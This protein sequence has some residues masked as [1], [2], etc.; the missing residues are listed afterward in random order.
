MSECY[1]MDKPILSMVMG[2][3]NGERFLREAIDSI[4]SQTF[5]DFEFIIVDDGSTDSS[6]DIVRSYS[7]TRIRLYLNES[8]HGISYTANR[9]ISLAR[10]KYVARMD[11]DDWSHPDRFRKQIEFLE[12]H[13]DIDILGTMRDSICDGRRTPPYWKWYIERPCDMRYM[14]NFDDYIYHTT[15]MFRREAYEKNNIRYD[16]CYK[17]A[18]DFDFCLKF[19][20]ACNASVLKDVLVTY[21][22]YESQ[23]TKNMGADLTWREPTEIIE[24]NF[25]SIQLDEAE[26]NALIMTRT[27]KD[28]YSIEQIE[29]LWRGLTDLYRIVECPMDRR[30]RRNRANIFWDIV[31]RNQN[32]GVH[33]LIKVLGNRVLSDAEVPM[34]I[35]LKFIVK[36]ILKHRS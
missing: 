6:V 1:E 25:N 5:S 18:N 10:G 36:C 9:G 7:D 30:G 16:E 31:N 26:R 24:K 14:M 29:S 23:T 17:Y 33:L 11:Q 3:Y 2:V 34:E 27:S 22:Y 35:R 12:S 20:R 15:M 19:V 8:N 21:R 4:L 13:P 32:L 28:S